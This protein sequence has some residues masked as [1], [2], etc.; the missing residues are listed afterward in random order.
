MHTM[1]FTNIEAIAELISLPTVFI[2]DLPIGAL[3]DVVALV[4]GAQNPRA[5]CMIGRN[6][7]LIFSWAPCL[8]PRNVQSGNNEVFLLSPPLLQVHSCVQLLHK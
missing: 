5:P 2:L 1:Q 7:P 6:I 8:S 3:V 4:I